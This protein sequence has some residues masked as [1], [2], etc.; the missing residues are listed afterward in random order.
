[1][2]G[3][4][5]KYTPELI[6]K[7]KDYLSDDDDINYKSEGDVVPTVVGLAITIGVVKSTVYDWAE[8]TEKEF[9]DMLALCN[10]KSERALIN[11]SLGNDMNSNIAKL[12]LSKHGYSE[13][14]DIKHTGDG[15]NMTMNFKAKGE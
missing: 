14:K 15:L 12:M 4:P 8:D 13:S 10:T 9:S 2:A 3:R 1:M 6:Q 11:G 7:A 5:S